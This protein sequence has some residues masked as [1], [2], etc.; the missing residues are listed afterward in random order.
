VILLEAFVTTGQVT[1]IPADLT[2]ESKIAQN[3]NGM[4]VFALPDADRC[5][6]DVASAFRRT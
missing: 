1:T 4:F 6:I 3:A 2:P 5:K